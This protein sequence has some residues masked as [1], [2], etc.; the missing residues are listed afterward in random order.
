AWFLVFR[1]LDKCLNPGGFIGGKS[2][3]VQQSSHK[4]LGRAAANGI[5]QLNHLLTSGG[6][7]RHRGRIEECPSYH[8]MSEP[9]LFLHP[10]KHGAHRFPRQLTSVREKL[11]NFDGGNLTPLPDDFHDLSLGVRQWLVGQFH[12]FSLASSRSH[13][14]YTL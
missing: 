10:L 1:L 6:I 12:G 3:I 4:P 9:P 11:S 2:S 7:P 5:D 14:G 8:A 13:Y